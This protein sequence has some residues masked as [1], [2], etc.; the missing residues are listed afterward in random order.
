M[1]HSHHKD[2][3]EARA[4]E[5][6]A[7]LASIDAELDVPAQQDW[8]D[9]ATEREADEVLERMG[10]S[11]QQELGRIAAALS[12]IAAGTYGRCVK[13]GD[14]IAGERL[15]LLPETPFCASCA[16]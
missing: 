8:E 4:A 3:L 10:R 12:R 9:Q 6:A 11:G 7:R 15:D 14:D 2:Q 13:C 1:T 5:L 16:A